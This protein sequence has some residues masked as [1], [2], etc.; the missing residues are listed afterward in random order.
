MALEVTDDNFA[1]KR[2][3]LNFK[4]LLNLSASASNMSQ[5]FS[6]YRCCFCRRLKIKL[7]LFLQ[8]DTNLCNMSK[9]SMIELR[10]GYTKKSL[11]KPQ[12]VYYLVNYG[13]CAL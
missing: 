10:P 8:T 6:I 4:R 11:V 13:N 3:N 12:L 9:R 2:F 5:D 7:N 1:L